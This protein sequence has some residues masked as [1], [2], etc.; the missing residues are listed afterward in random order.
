MFDR[1]EA[2]ERAILVH[3]NFNDEGNREDLHEL[4]M[5]VSSA[6]VNALSVVTGTR[7]RPHP[8]YFVGTGTAEE[9]A[10]EVKRDVK[11]RYMYAPSTYP[12]RKN[13]SPE[14]K[15]TYIYAPG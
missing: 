4:E 13:D 8:K 7:S 14:S 11:N 1:H 12:N 6:G 9:I 5:L 15:L 10:E 3:V 2:G